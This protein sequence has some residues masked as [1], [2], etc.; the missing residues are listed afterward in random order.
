[1]LKNLIIVLSFFHLFSSKVFSQEPSYFVLGQKEL[2]GLDI[3]DLYQ[4]SKS[5]YWVATNNGVYKY[6]G[7]DFKKIK[8][9]KIYSNSIFDLKENKNNEI[10]C[11]DFKGNIFQISGDSSSIFYVIPDSLKCNYITYDIDNQNNLIVFSNYLFKIYSRDRKIE[12]LSANPINVYGNIYKKEDNSIITYDEISSCILEIKNGELNYSKIELKDTNSIV[13]FINYNNNLISY[14]RTTGRLLK[15]VLNYNGSF[16]RFNPN[17]KLFNLRSDDKNIWINYLTGGTNLFNINKDKSELLYP[18]YIISSHFV[19]KEKNTLLGTFGHG[20]LVIPN[21]Y[22]KT[23]KTKKEVTQIT[24]TK[25]GD[26]LI[27]N[28]LGEVILLSKDKTKILNKKSNKRIEILEY[29]P[30][31]NQVFANCEQSTFI[32]ASN[33]KKTNFNTNSAKDICQIDSNTYLLATNLGLDLLRKNNG[34]VYITNLEEYTQR[35]YCVGYDSITKTI[36]SGSSIGLQVGTKDKFRLEKFN[37]ENII[38]SSIKFIKNK[39]FVSTI[40]QGVFIYSNNV[41]IENWN[42]NN[43]LLSNRVVQIIDYNENLFIATDKGICVMDFSGKYQFAINE[44]NGL[45][46]NNIIDFEIVNDILWVVTSE[47]FQTI[48]LNNLTNEVYYPKLHL[49][50]LFI[51]DVKTDTS[52]HSFSSYKNKFV[53]NL[54]SKSLKY[55]NDLTYLYKLEGFDDNWYTNDYKDH[56]IKYNFLPPSDYKFIVKAIYNGNSSNVIIYSFTIKK[57]YYKTIWFYLLLFTLILFFVI[58][59]FRIKITKQKKRSELQHKLDSVHLKALKSQMNPHFI[60]NSLNSI[61]DLIL[62]QDKENAYVYVSKFALLVRKILKYSDKDF[63]DFPDEIELLNLYLD[64]EKLRFKKDFTY[65]LNTN[66]ISDIEIPPMLIQPFIENSLKHG[67]L[68]KKGNKTLLIEFQLFEETLICYIEDNGIGRQKSSEIKQR[69]NRFY[70][71]FSTDSI[72]TRFELLQ[73]IYTQK[74]GVEYFDLYE[75]NFCKGTR[76]ELVIPFKRKF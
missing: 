54:E 16:P 45:K 66:K 65:Q 36:Y 56:I 19:D 5:N 63:I 3:Y 31:T 2:S 44:S 22:F 62:K 47:G 15:E 24:K 43:G 11:R 30:S 76:V 28:Q 46:N 52:I 72:N 39:I 23:I 67:L 37:N 4:D 55:S 64:L 35:T 32:N 7:Y 33:F 61:Q 17:N 13:M 27:G 53:F 34:E 51:N 20:I 48:D 57:P 26:V 38:A 49:R 71:S 25:T 69:Q 42:L 6:D 60:F 1:M 75:N 21:I 41:L 10:F 73:N 70:N 29:F 14:D 68:H 18:N 8:G 74:L 59:F 40:S 9:P 50:G 58:L 12:L